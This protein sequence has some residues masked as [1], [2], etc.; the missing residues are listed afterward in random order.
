MAN[1]RRPLNSVATILAACGVLVIVL[2]SSPAAVLAQE[3]LLLDDT[4]LANMYAPA[5]FFHAAELFRPQPVD[6]MVDTARLQRIH[7]NWLAI[8]VLNELS[9]A[10]LLSYDE[11]YALDVWYGSQGESN[12]INYTAHRDFYQATLHPEFGG[13]P[14]V[15]YARVVR[16]INSHTII[17]QYWLF[18]YYNDWFNKHEGDWEMVQV[19]LSEAGDPQWLVLSQHHGGTRRSWQ[20]IHTV[21]GTHP[22]VYVALGSHANYFIGDEIYPNGKT[23]GNV[24]VEIMDRTGSSGQV[25]PSITLLPGCHEVTSDPGRW[26]GLEWLA[27]G[28]YWGERGPQRDFS[29]PLGPC[30]KGEQWDQPFQWGLE[31]PLDAEVWYLNRLRV[32]IE[33]TEGSRVDIRGAAG[34][35]LPDAASLGDIALLHRDPLEGEE[36]IANIQVSPQS[37][38]GVTVTWPDRDSSSVTH[39]TFSDLRAGNTGQVSFRLAETDVPRLAIGGLMD[40]TEPDSVEVENTTW[41]APDLIWVAG[42]LPVTDVLLGVGISILAALLP[43]LAYVGILYW[44][45]RYEKEPKRLLASAFFWGAIPAIVI[46]IAVRIFFRLPPDMLGTNAVEVLQVG[47]VGPFVE[48]AIKGIAIFYIARRYYLEFDDV[49]DGIVYGAMAGFGFAMTGNLLSYLGAFLLRGFSGL[50]SVIFIQ[51]V[52]YGLNHAMYSSIFGAGLGFGRLAKKRWVRWTAPLVAFVISVIVH[53]LHNLAV[54]NAV[55]FSPITVTLTWA[56]ILV[57]VIVMLLAVR[58]QRRYMVEELQGEVPDEI[59]AIMT[60][61]GSRRKAYWAALR[62]GGIRGWRYSRKM[63]QLCAEL[64]IKKMQLSLD[65]DEPRL[66][67]EAA[68]LRGELDAIIKK[69]QQMGVN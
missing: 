13:P 7:P 42:L 56:G 63:G 41:D 6:V 44:A 43:T 58:K 17:I 35:E 67:K 40:T 32:Q 22:A 9:I 66:L 10:D 8:N 4:E 21:D 54:E 61:S 33:G 5:L 20:S 25:I 36:F 45:D 68:R 11:N 59:Y 12:S 3:A 38:F 53:A 48:E 49:L 14:I 46:A 55:G 62:Q 16:D 51:G 60:S 27:F 64:A 52:L 29:G 28:G 23:I 1:D 34:E 39:Y 31:Q 18:Y 47:L 19:M 30:S 65:P 37:Q 24:R 50:S 26:S 2:L 57:I 69:W 15:A